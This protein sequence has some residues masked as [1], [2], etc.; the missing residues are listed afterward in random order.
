MKIQAITPFNFINRKQ[1]TQKT[2]PQNNTQNYAYNPVAYNDLTFTARLFR[3][4]ENF[5]AQSFNKNGMP[6]TMK[7]YLNADYEDR[8]KMPPAQMLK[9]VF[10]DVNG[11]KKLEQV[12]RLYPDEPLF[13]NLT[14]V[15]NKNSRTGVLA[16]IDLMREDGKTLFKNGKDNLGHYILTKIYTETKTLKEINADF[17]KDVSVHYS[18]LSDIEYDTLRAFGIRFPNNSFWKSLTATREEFPYEYKP[19]KPLET[20]ATSTNS[21]NS[22]TAKPTPR[23]RGRFE[24]VKDWEVDKLADALNKGVGDAAETRKQLRKTSVRD[25]ASLNFVAKYMGEINSVVLEKLHVSPEMR[26]F[27]ENS[28]LMTK[29]QKQKL[30]TYWQDPERRELRSIIMKDTIRLFFEA[31]GVDGQ[32]D[33]FK[34]LLEY[35]QGIKPAR[36]AQQAEHNRIQAEYDEFFAKL[37][38]QEQTLPRQN[39]EPAEPPT[40][41]ELLSSAKEGMDVEEFRFDTKQ[42]E[43]VILANLKEALEEN[44][45]KETAFMPKSISDKYVKFIVTNDDLPKSY[46]LS[47]LLMGHG[48]DLPADGRLMSE[49]RTEDTS[50]DIQCDFTRLNLIECRAAQQA[51]CDLLSSIV[52]SSVPHLF[53]MGLFEFIPLFSHLDENGQKQIANKNGSLNAK[54]SYYKK[55][56]TDSEVS[57]ISKEVIDILR[58]YNP[59]T[60]VIDGRSPFKG[61]ESTF[62]SLS[63]YLRNQNP[64]DFK[65][66]V[67]RY[68]KEYGGSMRYLLDKNV[69]SQLKQTK[70]E[71]L[72]V[73]YAFDKNQEFCWF[74]S[75]DEEGLD[76]IKRT[77]PEIYVLLNGTM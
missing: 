11:T 10:D 31:Y 8:Q 49:N 60:T 45:R 19:R 64:S 5:Y 25:E 32:N 68:I 22:V 66:S 7:Q 12:K 4:P 36:L 75:R 67:T 20:R 42:G 59:K 9:L 24:G 55:P 41:E 33:D 15:P 48:I 23:Q 52:S 39:I 16:E 26:E 69:S 21:T 46:I 62:Y 14:D 65:A 77:A 71:Q 29:S 28:E 73:N 1:S 74:I 57:K 30:E 6:E 61:Y 27:F 51:V 58:N 40:Y 35:A 72:M 38:A 13:A 63:C 70:V 34:E 54:Y 44:L 47:K 76:F 17:K 50:L 43:V 2:T 56:L 37:D 3:T 18:G 53:S